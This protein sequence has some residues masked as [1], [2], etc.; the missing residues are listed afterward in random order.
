[1]Q[2]QQNEPS[3]I[4][5]MKATHSRGVFI[6]QSLAITVEVFLHRRFGRRYGGIA[7]GVG[8]LLIFLVMAFGAPYSPMPML[9][10]LGAYILMLAA[11]RIERV[12]AEARGEVRHSRYNGEPRLARFFPKLDEISIKRWIEPPLVMFVGML[13]MGFSPPLGLYLFFA[14]IAMG[15]NVSGIV[16]YERAKATAAVDSLIDARMHAARVRERMGAM[17]GFLN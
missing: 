8:G 4:E 13:T 6:C 14:G 15:V 11:V 12:A 3:L 7:A 5:R 1:M 10:F 17:G 9:L 2:Q 16:A